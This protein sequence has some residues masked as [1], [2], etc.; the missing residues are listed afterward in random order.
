MTQKGVVNWSTTAASNNTSD[1]NNS[2]GWSE[3]QAPSTVNDSA[4]AM[5]SSVALWRDDITGVLVTAGSGT[6]FTLTTNQVFSS[7]AAGYTVQ[8]VSGATN[9]GAVT[10]AVDGNTAKPL[11]FLTGV[12]L[13]SGVL[14]SGS[15]Y[16]ATF[17]TASDEWL[18]HSTPLAAPFIVPLGGI[19]DYTG[20][21]V[22]SANF[23]LPQ[24]QA[25]SRTTYATLFSL[26]STT[27]GVGD[28][29]TTFN[30][31]DLVGRVIAMR[32]VGSARLSA[33]YFG[34]NP[35]NL[36]AAGGLESHTL[37]AAQIPSITSTASPSL[38]V[39]VNSANWVAS[40]SSDSTAFSLQS[41]ASGALGVSL[42]GGS[43][44]KIASSGSATGTVSSTSNNT[45][46][47]AH[48]NVQPTLVLN[49]IMR[50][51]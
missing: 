49:K 50:I 14:I 10:L 21:S 11:R 48:N 17:R 26:I 51:L 25:I 40:S 24:G 47:A 2:V 3:G 30:I 20:A 42:T 1:A 43:V 31:P 29:S 45:S 46:G 36:G 41:G 44:S 28:N 38:T 5:M 35:A 16:Q 4:R 12:D 7:N 6:A 19:I 27:Y 8:F 34:G 13:P 37:T 33:T 39:S 15:L 23:A 18:L 22:P 9:T 32:D